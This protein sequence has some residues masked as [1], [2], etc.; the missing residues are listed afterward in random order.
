MKTTIPNQ[1]KEI[2]PVLQKYKTDIQKLYGNQFEKL[3]LYGSYARGNQHSESDIDLLLIINKMDTPYKEVDKMSELTYNYMLDYDMFFSVVP[4][5][6]DKFN[7]MANPLYY[8][9]KKEGISL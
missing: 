6:A 5:T 3:I 1:I 9:V 2:L 8:N 4:T 7:N